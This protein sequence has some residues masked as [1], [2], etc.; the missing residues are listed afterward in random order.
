MRQV[1]K[2]NPALMANLSSTRL[3]NGNNEIIVKCSQVK[4][5]GKHGLWFVKAYLL[6]LKLRLYLHTLPT[7]RRMDN[8]FRLS[9][10]AGGGRI[11]KCF[12]SQEIFKGH[13][14]HSNP[15]NKFPSDRKYHFML[16]SFFFVCVRNEASKQ[17]EVMTG[18]RDSLNVLSTTGNST[19]VAAINIHTATTKKFLKI[20]FR[21]PVS[22]GVLRL[23]FFNSFFLSVCTWVY[24]IKVWWSKWS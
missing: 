3:T 11:Q 2:P 24:S 22:P 15:N 1:T 4:P 19:W 6:D 14:K 17:L 7:D 9:T 13:M 21:K 18:Q 5:G 23:G 8:M 16:F 12:L 10:E 20:H